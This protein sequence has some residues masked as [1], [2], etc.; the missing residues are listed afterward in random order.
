MHAVDEGESLPDELDRVDLREARAVVAV[1]DVAKLGDELLLHLPRIADAERGEPLRQRLDPLVHRVDEQAGEARHVLVRQLP[2]HAEVDEADLLRRLEHHDVGG[3]R[4]GM[5]EAV[6]EDHVHLRLG[7]QIGEPP[8]LLQRVRLGV[9][10]P[11]LHAL[12]ELQREHA[13]ARVAPEDA[14][15]SHM[16]MPG[17]VAVELL[18]VARLHAVIELLADRAR[19]LVHERGGVDELERLDA[20]ADEARRLVH[21]LEVGLDLPRRVRSLHLHRD[22]APIGQR[23]PVNLA[24][25]RC[26]DGRFLE[27]EKELLDGQLELLLNDAFDLGVR[28]G[29]DVVLER[30]ELED[31]VGRDDVRARREKLAELDEGRPELVEH[32]PDAEAAVRAVRGDVD[33][34]S[35]ARAHPVRP[36]GVEEVPEAVLGRDLRDL[37]EAAELADSRPGA[38][39]SFFS[40]RRSRCSTCAKRSSSS[41]YSRLVMRPSSRKS[42][43]SVV[44]ARSLMR[45]ASPRQRPMT[46]STRSRASSPVIFPRPTSSWTSS[47][48]RSFVSATAPTPARIASSASPRSDFASLFSLARSSMGLRAPALAPRL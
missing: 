8:P 45:T 12:E 18:G 35:A 5:E 47:S 26:R 7:D 32:L 2:D 30:L 37:R 48:A 38:H 3:V 42:T 19:E 16:R 17:E 21:Q 40:T 15:N 13:R 46:S 20:V 10:V 36:V 11:K 28:D 39:W 9:E 41:S 25:G 24:D 14:R 43:E 31:D 1:V 33:F 22:A 23:G 29:R 6:P 34:P 4:V 44:P 27:V